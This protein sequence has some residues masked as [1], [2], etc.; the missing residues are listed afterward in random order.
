MSATMDDLMRGVAEMGQYNQDLRKEN[1][2]L[3]TELDQLRDEIENT[4]QRTEFWDKQQEM[5]TNGLAKSR[6]E[7][8]NLLREIWHANAERAQAEETYSKVSA[9][10]QKKLKAKFV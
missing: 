9:E 5:T 1:N 3:R 6:D 8:V 4:K 2:E 7:A 10:I